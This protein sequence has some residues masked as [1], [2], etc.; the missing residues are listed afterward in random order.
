MVKDMSLGSMYDMIDLKLVMR[1]DA[2]RLMSK[3]RGVN[4]D[5]L[6]TGRSVISL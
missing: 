3:C 2:G 1:G 5:R 4:P 6:S